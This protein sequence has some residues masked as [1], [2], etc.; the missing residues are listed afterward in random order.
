MNV[1][2]HFCFLASLRFLP[3]HPFLLSTECVDVGCCCCR[4]PL[5]DTVGSLALHLLLRLL[6]LSVDI[7]HTYTNTFMA[8]CT[9]QWL[10]YCMLHSDHGRYDH[11]GYKLN[12]MCNKI[13][14]WLESKWN[15]MPKK[16]G[17]RPESIE[18]KPD[19]TK[20]S[21]WQFSS[22]PPSFGPSRNVEHDLSFS[23]VAI[24]MCFFIWSFIR[25]GRAELL[26]RQYYTHLYALDSANM[27]LLR[28]PKDGCL[29]IFFW[30]AMKGI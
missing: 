23:V 18:R 25:Y 2:F 26:R 19:T 27:L 9:A 4:W 13:S 14:G 20:C 16:M 12:A 21:V 22:S 15:E 30:L 17:S 24:K 28:L 11:S 3:R 8:F 7:R 1:F 10:H 5:C 6:C 29:Y